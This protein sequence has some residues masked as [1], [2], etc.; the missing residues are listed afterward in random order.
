M[1]DDIY[2]RLSMLIKDWG[3]ELGFQAVGIT[4]TQLG[5]HES[6]LASWLADD[7]HGE[8]KY[9][10]A[11]GTKRS[12]PTELVPGTER[13]ICVRLDYLK[14]HKAQDL[15]ASDSNTDQK[16]YVARYALGRDYHKVIRKRLLKLWQ[17]I[18]HFLAEAEI[19]HHQAR[20]FTDSAPILEK[21]LAEKAGL[22]WIGKNAMLINSSMGSWF[23]LGELFT[24]LPLPIDTPQTT[25]HCGSC[26]ACL[27]ICPTNAFIGPYELDARKCISYL[28]IELKGSI[29]EA[30]A[31][32]KDLRENYG[33][34][35]SI[36]VYPV[37][38]KGLI[39][40]RLIPTSS[41]TLEDVRITLDAFSSI[42]ERLENGTY[43]RLSAAIMASAE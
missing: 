24:D 35:C 29:P 2:Q 9:M 37:I 38:P 31:L 36:V 1:T 20:V 25:K 10:A 15:I 3:K 18:E 43:K 19:T 34:F 39:L 7:Y 23:F 26:T 17:R 22:G 40:L 21:A 28:T 16:A 14:D 42:R 5:E 11:H 27:D 8:M 32:V 41:H 12:R 30:M 13:I 33:I 4:D 6:H